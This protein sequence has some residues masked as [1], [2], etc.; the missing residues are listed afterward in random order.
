MPTPILP[1]RQWPSTRGKKLLASPT[2]PL[3]SASRGD[4]FRRFVRS[5]SLRPSWLLAPCADPTK[6][7]QCPPRPPRAFTSGLPVPKELPDMTTAP[8]GNLRR[9]DFHPQVQQLASLRSL[10]RV[11]VGSSSPASA[12]LSRRYDF[13][14]PI[15]PHFVFLRL[16]VP[17]DHACFAPG[18]ATCGNVGPGV[19]H[20]VPP[21]GNYRGDDRISHVPGEPRLCLCPALRPRRTDHIRPLRCGGT[22]LILTTR[23]ATAMNFRGSITRLWHWLS[24]LCRVGHP[25]AT[26]DSL[27][28]AGQALPDG[29][30]YP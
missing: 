15:P 30:D 7:V 6:M 5:L 26:Q 10:P 2:S 21:A 13:L 16:A 17:R 12:V 18:V 20:P 27:P 22:A 4:P 11:F 24:T 9:R 8:H 28:A 25:T 29:L 3:E 19:G 23:K 14:P 1:R